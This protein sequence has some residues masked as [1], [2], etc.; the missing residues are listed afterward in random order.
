MPFKAKIDAKGKKQKLDRNV[1]LENRLLELG[2]TRDVV[3]SWN[4]EEQ[5][6]ELE[7]LEGRTP[8]SREIT[9]DELF[10]EAHENFVPT[11]PS[12][13]PT[14]VEAA[15]AEPAAPVEQIDSEIDH[16]N[17]M[18]VD[19][20]EAFGR[21]PAAE[22]I[23]DGND[24]LLT[25]PMEPPIA[26]QLAAEPAG[27]LPQLLAPLDDQAREQID[28][29]PYEQQIAT[30]QQISAEQWSFLMTPPSQPIRG[31]PLAGVP[32]DLRPVAT[33][34]PPHLQAFL[35]RIPEHVQRMV[36]G[37]PA[38]EMYRQL[39]KGRRTLISHRERREQ[40]RRQI[41]LDVL[42]PLNPYV[43]HWLQSTSNATQQNY[44]TSDWFH[45]Y[46]M[47]LDNNMLIHIQNWGP[48]AG[49]PVS[50]PEDLRVAEQIAMQ[51]NRHNDP[52]A[53]LYS[54]ARV[55][56]IRWAMRSREMINR[57]MRNR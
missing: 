35:G 17:A 19:E 32:A 44:L 41:E 36:L 29:M 15:D 9:F 43:S 20:E 42:L 1:G 33:Q 31:D 55:E 38:L 2:I 14:A 46:A 27:P 13:P 16:L 12:P 26:A 3:F 51:H 18:D 11:P 47:L 28:S 25:Q 5:S 4:R 40:F 23:N 53:W 7:R 45:R 57:A 8:R 10:A 24:W 49:P 30:L 52:Q 54:T 34:L 37:M 39:Y 21:L 50:V 48:Y 56:W 22:T 6:A